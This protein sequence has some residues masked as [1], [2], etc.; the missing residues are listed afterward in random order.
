MALL[1]FFY[2]FNVTGKYKNNDQTKERSLAASD[3][4]ILKAKIL[5]I[6]TLHRLQ[7]ALVA[8]R[9]TEYE[10]TMYVSYNVLK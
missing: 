5:Q 4:G 8:V 9:C 1:S 6:S 10:V 3:F 7:S 2:Y